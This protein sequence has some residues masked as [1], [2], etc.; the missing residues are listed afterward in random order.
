M[1][2]ASAN[3]TSTG[4]IN[5]VLQ[6][7]IRAASRWLLL[8]FICGVLAFLGAQI[9]NTSTEGLLPAFIFGA[10]VNVVVS[11]FL[12]SGSDRSGSVALLFGDLILAMLFAQVGQ[13]NVFVLVI[14]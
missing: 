1:S 6:N 2:N 14:S 5:T 9:G 4:G 12:L 11:L 7:R 8:L 10:L 13:G 3:G